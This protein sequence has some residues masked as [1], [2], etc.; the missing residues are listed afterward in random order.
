MIFVYVRPYPV[1]SPITN[2]T[3]AFLKSGRPLLLGSG[4]PEAVVDEL[5]SGATREL[6]D[7]TLR[8]WIRLQRVY[9]RKK[10]S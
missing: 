6:V 4:V 7:A 8:Q 3:Q 2:H 5:Q 10:R 1:Q 9:A